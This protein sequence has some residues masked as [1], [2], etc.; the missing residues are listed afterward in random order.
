MQ[1]AQKLLEEKMVSFF[2][3]ISGFEK[4][5]NDLLVH[6]VS[7]VKTEPLW[8]ILTNQDPATFSTSLTKRETKDLGDLCE[9]MIAFFADEVVAE[10][11]YLAN[12]KGIQYGSDP[13]PSPGLNVAVEAFGERGVAYCADLLA[14]YELAVE[15]ISLYDDA[16]IAA[17]IT[18]VSGDVLPF[19]RIPKSDLVD[20]INLMTALREMMDDE[21]PQS[22][23]YSSVVSSWQKYIG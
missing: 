12:I 5:S 9:Q 13:I 14:L 8:T 18:A 19:S 7:Q 21:T 4:I 23:D 3:K 11:D 22:S 10:D 15:S 17:A 16:Q 6:Y 2:E 20:G 1:T